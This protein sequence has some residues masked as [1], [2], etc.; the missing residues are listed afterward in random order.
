MV[1]RFYLG[2]PIA[3]GDELWRFHLHG[4]QCDPRPRQPHASNDDRA[5]HSNY[6]RGLIALGDSL[7]APGG[8]ACC[9][10]EYA[11]SESRYEARGTKPLEKRY[12]L[13]RGGFEPPTHWLKASCSTD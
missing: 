1:C 8:I 13:S 9:A 12:K 2:A 4:S 3:T 10:G 11:Y 7:D 6:T 5:A